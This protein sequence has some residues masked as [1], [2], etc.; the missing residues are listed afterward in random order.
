MRP[1]RVDDPRRP[2]HDRTLQLPS[3]LQP[4][5]RQT[6]YHEG[7]WK[8]VFHGDFGGTPPVQHIR[9]EIAGGLANLKVVGSEILG[10]VAVAKVR[11]EQ[12]ARSYGNQGNAQ[13]KALETVKHS[14]GRILASKAN[15]ASYLGENSSGQRKGTLF[16]SSQI[17]PA[18]HRW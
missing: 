6:V 8:Q 13:K 14:I 16:R 11:I 18:G 5:E 3:V 9:C 2:L 10:T 7:F 4:F 1:R 12:N 17:P 15:H